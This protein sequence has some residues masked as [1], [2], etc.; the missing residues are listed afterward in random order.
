M[1]TPLAEA[2]RFEHNK[3]V[4]ILLKNHADVELSNALG[5]KPILMA[6]RDGNYEYVVMN[7]MN[8]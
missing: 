6:A 3:A 7:K 2:V 1:G 5:E 4:K 8:N